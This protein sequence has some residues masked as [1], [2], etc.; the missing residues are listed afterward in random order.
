MIYWY[1]KLDFGKCGVDLHM[2]R[3]TELRV[4]EVMMLSTGKGS[5]KHG[6]VPGFR[7]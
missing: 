5:I 6:E 2:I 4:D 1:R 3:Q 7:Q